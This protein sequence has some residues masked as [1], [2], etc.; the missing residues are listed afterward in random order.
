[1]A[2]QSPFSLLDGI[3]SKLSTTLQP[4]SWA[5]DEFQHRLVLFI[6]HV[7]MQEKEAQA[8][9][10]RQSGS[11]ISLRW[12]NMSM[13]VAAT[14][15]GLLECLSPQGPSDLSLTVTEESPVAL[16]QAMAVGA[17]PGV[18]IEGDVQL[19]AEIN[20]LADHVRWDVEEDLSR[21]IGDAP[22]HAMAGIARQVSGALRNFMVSKN[23]PS[24]DG[25]SAP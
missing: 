5:V 1:M 15:A 6:N 7:L 3:F 11:I 21:V 10:A 25:K 14:P 18:N 8:R 24:A 2:T 13:R 19:A 23:T 9:M 20:W 12:R 16:L 22:A 17:K 4:P